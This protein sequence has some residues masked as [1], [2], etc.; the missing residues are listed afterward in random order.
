MKFLNFEHYFFLFSDKQHIAVTSK[1]AVTHSK[2]NEAMNSNQ[3]N[4]TN[5]SN[6]TT[7]ILQ[8]W[9]NI[10]EL[11]GE[12]PVVIPPKAVFLTPRS[13]RDVRPLT[14]DEKIVPRE[15]IG[16]SC[17]LNRGY[18]LLQRFLPDAENDSHAELLRQNYVFDKAFPEY[19][20]SFS[21][22]ETDGRTIHCE[23]CNTDIRATSISKQKAHL[24]ID[25]VGV[26][27]DPVICIC[28]GAEWANLTQGRVCTVHYSKCKPEE[29]FQS[30]IAWIDEYAQFIQDKP[31][32]DR[33]T[34]IGI[35]KVG[36][37]RSPENKFSKENCS[38][39]Y[40]R[41]N[42]WVFGV[43]EPKLQN[44]RRGRLLDA[45]NGALRVLGR[46]KLPFPMLTFEGTPDEEVSALLLNILP[47]MNLQV[48][49]DIR[50]P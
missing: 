33:F 10:H 49:M 5:V 37:N 45:L 17:M 46:P 24:L 48:A 16:A 32:P 29:Q 26:R 50:N 44:P 9:E 25:C 8:T 22:T 39:M 20:G 6:E 43:S 31:I 4:A 13:V 34:R 30:R 19:T 41:I 28:C 21:V 47:R 42:K 3:G 7:D 1:H 18:P 12:Q 15:H 36:F 38:K 23:R 40:D 35:N 27:M 14:Q 11:V 2:F